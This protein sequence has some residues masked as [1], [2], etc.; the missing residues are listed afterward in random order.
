MGK[1][2]DNRAPNSLFPQIV[3]CIGVKCPC[4]FY[5]ATEKACNKESLQQTVY[6]YCVKSISFYLL[7]FLLSLDLIMSAEELTVQSIWKVH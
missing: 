3:W 1:R 5:N 4:I 7:S 6:C 2:T